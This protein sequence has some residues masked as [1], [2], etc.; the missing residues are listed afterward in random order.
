MG[1]L[2]GLQF[3]PALLPLFLG[4]L[5]PKVFFA[6][7]GLGA[8]A[9]LAHGLW[10]WRRGKLGSSSI[11]LLIAAVALVVSAGLY[12][13]QQYKTR[14]LQEQV[15]TQLILIGQL[16]NDLS[17]AK[18]ANDELARAVDRQNEAALR[19]ERERTRINRQAEEAIQQLVVKS[20]AQRARV[21]KL[22]TGPEAMNEYFGQQ[23]Q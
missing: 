3:A 9:I 18:N 15:S 11:P 2:F 5:A 1:T 7:T 17:A 16:R 23:R 20:K 10:S 21:A 22:P 12:K 19:A 6:V 13:A 8:L 14:K 4:L